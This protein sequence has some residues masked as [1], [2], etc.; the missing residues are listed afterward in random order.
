MRRKIENI[1]NVRYVHFLS[2]SECN[3]DIFIFEYLEVVEN[4]NLQG[5]E[6][7]MKVRTSEY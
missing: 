1:I 2:E 7:R 6:T 5:K 3:S 4:R